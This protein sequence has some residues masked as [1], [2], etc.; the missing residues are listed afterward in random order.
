M[1]KQIIDGVDVS[2]CKYIDIENFEKP[3]CHCISQRNECEMPCEYNKDCHYKQL[4][5]KEQECEE[6]K[7]AIDR[8]LK[9]QYQLADSCTKYEQTLA[10]IKEIAEECY[11]KCNSMNNCNISCKYYN[12]CNGEF[13]YLLACL[14]KQ[15]SEC[16][17]ENDNK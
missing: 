7:E 4:K 14:N 15:I 3:I 5:R 11:Y 6:L 1:D 17:V 12:N 10:E 13:S 8:L 16:E 2:G 9:I